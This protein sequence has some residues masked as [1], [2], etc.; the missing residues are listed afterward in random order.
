MLVPYEIPILITSDNSLNNVIVSQNG[1]QAI[2]QLKEPIK[3]PSSALNVSVELEQ[4]LIWN[5]NPNI[6]ENTF[7]DINGNSLN[8]FVGLYEIDSLNKIISDFIYYSGISLLGDKF[9][10]EANDVGSNL[11]MIFDNQNVALSVTLALPIATLLGFNTTPYSNPA[12]PN[13]NKFNSIAPAQLNQTEFLLC[14]VPS[15]VANG[16]LINNQYSSVVAQLAL[17]APPQFQIIYETTAPCQLSTN[18]AG[19]NI[20]QILVYWTDNKLLP[21]NTMGEKWTVRLSINYLNPELIKN[22][23]GE[24][25]V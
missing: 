17:T 2:V 1:S 6:K 12:S 24:I 5:N 22:A 3:I 20:S 25:I 14:H 7:I 16:I 10:F 11:T 18:L 8:I 23:K 9:Y 21:L 13:R 15:L 4:A 19:T